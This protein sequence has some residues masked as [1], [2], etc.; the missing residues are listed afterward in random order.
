MQWIEPIEVVRAR[1]KFW[2]Q[3][4]ITV[5]LILFTLVFP[6][7]CFGLMAAIGIRLKTGTWQ[8]GLSSLIGSLSSCGFLVMH[9]LNRPSIVQQ[10]IFLGPESFTIRHGKSNITTTF[11]QLRGYS[12][13]QDLSNDSVLRVFILYPR[14]EGQFAVGLPEYIDDG[15]IHSILSQHVPF[16]TIFD[17]QSLKHP[18]L[19]K[20]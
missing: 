19:E 15:A 12:I 11:D 2:N 9:S 7:V 1:K 10:E 17:K 14:S 3:P 20:H 4:S 16:I 6:F 5:P 18:F 13:I 8:F